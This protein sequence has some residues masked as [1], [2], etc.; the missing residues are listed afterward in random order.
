MA[1]REEMRIR[2]H[3]IITYLDQTYGDNW[4]QDPEITEHP[5]LKEHLKWIKTCR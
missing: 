3:N 2:T 5:K 1:E 4:A